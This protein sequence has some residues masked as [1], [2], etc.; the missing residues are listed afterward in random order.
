MVTVKEL[1]ELASVSVRTLHYYD[2]IDLLKPAKVGANGYRYYDDAALLRL[3]QILFYRELGLEL[4]QIKAALDDPTFNVVTVLGEHR[5]A[6]VR[7]IS[8][9][10]ALIHTVDETIAH[11][12]QGKP[13]S[14]KKLFQGFDAA[15]QKQYEREIRLE[16]GPD[17]VKESVQNWGSYTAEQK[18]HIMDEGNLLYSEIVDAIQ[19]GLAPEDPDVQTLMGRWHLHIRY[20]YEPTLEI[21]RGLGDLYTSHPDFIANFAQMHPQLGDYMKD[22]ILQYVDA[23]ETAEIMRL[24]AE[25]DANRLEG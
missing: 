8:R 11:L 21:L 12:T 18:A 9:H 10:R 14:K 19:R 20:F 25:D 3:Q 4:A 17:K 7:Q 16:Y 1:A 2:E 13:M 22:A 6:L 24:L 5:A 15:Q 23:L